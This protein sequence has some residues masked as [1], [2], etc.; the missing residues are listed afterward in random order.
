MIRAMLLEFHQAMGYT[1]PKDRELHRLSVQFAEKHLA[2]IPDF[3]SY[4]RVW[5]AAE[6]NGDIPVRVTGALGFT[7]RPDFTL[8]RFTDRQ[9]IVALHNRANAYLSDNGA[10]GSDAMVYVNSKEGPEQRC[11]EWEATLAALKATPSDRWLIKIL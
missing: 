3:S 10:R 1:M 5:V 9:T 11:P 6:M 8:A 2:E 7:F 4:N